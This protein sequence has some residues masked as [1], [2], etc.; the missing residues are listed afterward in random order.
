[1]I[2]EGL[3]SRIDQLIENA[4]SQFKAKPLSRDVGNQKNIEE[5]LQSLTDLPK[6][7]DGYKA[8]GVNP[9]NADFAAKILSVLP[10]NTP[11]PQIVPG[12]GGDLQIEWHTETI[13]IE[14]HIMSPDAVD[15][16]VSS[17]EDDGVEFKLTT[18]NLFI[19]Y[20]IVL[21]WRASGYIAPWPFLREPLVQGSSLLDFLV[22]DKIDKEAIQFL[23]ARLTMREADWSDLSDPFQ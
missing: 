7:W 9:A 12:T 8:E 3:E 1:M 14:I 15:V 20:Q 11:A 13:E 5:K 2:D 21:D 10:K 4:F 18:P 23:G 19:F 16:W 6:G 17:G 22:A